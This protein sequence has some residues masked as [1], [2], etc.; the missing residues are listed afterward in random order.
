MGLFK[1]QGTELEKVLG[2]LNF[3]YFWGMPDIPYIFGGYRVDARVQA[4][5]FRKNKSNPN[6]VRHLYH[7]NY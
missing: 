5:V 7:L 3:I 2:L 6:G 4:Y 1:G